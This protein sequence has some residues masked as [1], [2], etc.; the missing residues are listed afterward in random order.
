MIVAVAMSIGARRLL[1]RETIYTLKLVRRGRS[2]PKAR[3]ANM[4]L[5]RSARDVMDADI[6]VLP[7][8]ASFDDYLRQPEHAGRLRHVVVTDKKGHMYGVIRVNTGLRRG[9]EATHTGVTLGEVASRNFA[10]VRESETA[11]DVIRRM[12]R[13]GAIMAVVVRGRGVPSGSDVAG[14]ITKEHVADSVADSIKAYPE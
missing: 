12:W 7:A 9:L 6:Q 11:F 3:H 13:Q 1:S 4:F 14:V 10:V 2:I 8:D 5:V